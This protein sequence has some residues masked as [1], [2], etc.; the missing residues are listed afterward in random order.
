MGEHKM[1]IFLVTAYKSYSLSITSALQIRL[2]HSKNTA[3]KY[4]EIKAAFKV[5]YQQVIMFKLKTVTIT[6]CTTAKKINLKTISHCH[7]MP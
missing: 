3:N 1:N 5:L 6:T 4:D 2:M 7:Q